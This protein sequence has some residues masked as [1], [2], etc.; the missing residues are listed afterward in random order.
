MKIVRSIPQWQKIRASLGSMSVG[1]IPTMGALHAGHRSLVERARFE[2]Q[3]VVSSIFVNPTQFNDPKDFEKYPKTWESDVAQL[4]K[5][6][7]DY[8]LSPELSEIYPDQ[9][10]YLVDEKEFSRLLCGSHRPGHF[11]G[12][13]SVVMKLLNLVRPDRAYFGEKDYQQLKLIEGMVD[14]FF[15]PTQIVPCPTVREPDGLAMSSRNVRLSAAERE[16][17]PIFHR[18]LS[19]GRSLTE[20]RSELERSGF[21]VDYIEEISGRRFGAVK[22]GEVRLIDNVPVGA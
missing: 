8:L 10:R 15:M 5:A 1:F 6:G 17:A 19:S 18:S 13:L 12:V 3:V 20:I 2:N 9:Y 22:L 21:E 14:A 11:Q 7:C 4:E 16:R